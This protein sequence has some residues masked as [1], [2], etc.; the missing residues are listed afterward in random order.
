[1][2][3]VSGEALFDV[4]AGQE[5]ASGLTLDARIGGSPLNVAIGLAR[6][7]RPVAFFGGVSRGFLGERLMR[8]LA[9]EGVDASCI[10]RLDARTTL[11]LVGVGPG[12]APDYAFYGVGSA[13]R[14]LTPDRLDALLQAG[15]YH[16]A[17]FAM[18]VEPVGSTLKALMRRKAG[19][20]LISWDP[21]IRLNVEP[22]PA[23]W[24][25]L[26]DEV[27]PLCDMVKV[28]DEDL[29]LLFPGRTPRAVLEEWS[30]RGPALAVLTQGGE[31]VLAIAGG[32][33]VE[34]PSVPVSVVDTVGAGDTFIAALLARLDETGQLSRAALEAM[35]EAGLSALIDFAAQAAS[36]TCSRRGADLPRRA[37][38][39]L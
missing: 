15:A 5:T 9:S 19:G 12:G 21:N 10:V 1:M 24:R 28:S 37:E 34:R 35:D 4:Y 26:A 17:S 31:G 6:M 32:R 11:S 36:I 38:L 8:A 7:G 2:I 22:D 14:L 13:D 16:F 3:I 18:V 20:A 29:R 27:L 23:V 33:R 25:A 39:P 30:R